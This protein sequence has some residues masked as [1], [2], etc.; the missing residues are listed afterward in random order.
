MQ[1][2]IVM[3]LRRLFWLSMGL[4]VGVG[5]FARPAKAAAGTEAAAFLNIPVGAGPAA[6]GG[7]YTAL[8]SDAYAPTWN[9]AGLGQVHN[10][11]ISGQHLSYLESIHYEYLSLAH[12]LGQ[13]GAF[14]ASIQYLGTGDI[15]GTDRFGDPNGDFSAMYAAYSLAYGHRFGERLSLGLTTKMIHAKLSDVTATAWAGDLG[16][17]YKAN[18][19]LNL[20]AVAANMGTTLKFLEEKGNLPLALR[21]SGAWTPLRPL[22]VAVEGVFPK[23][24]DPSAHLGVAWRPIP[25]VSL[26]TGFRTD[27]LKENDTLAGFSTGIGID[28]WGQEF[29]YAW[30]PYGDL[31]NTQYFSLLIRF[32]TQEERRRNLIHYQS[33]KKHQLAGSSSSAEDALTPDYQQIMQLL[34]DTDRDYLS[35][36]QDGRKEQ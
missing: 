25:M 33:I 22:T 3:T 20:A 30:V 18:D 4:A 19:R 5:L 6:M 14:G 17:H 10:T 26:R 2:P 32:G 13:K 1:L 15:A 27:T 35:Q 34:S 12:P 11:Q 29:A 8:A 23:E 7:A 24:T 21:V 31:G 28:V 36:T 9:P 16:L